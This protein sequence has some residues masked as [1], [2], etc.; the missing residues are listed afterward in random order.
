MQILE[1]GPD[2][3]MQISSL[4]QQERLVNHFLHQDVLE[5]PGRLRDHTHG[6]HQVLAHQDV[7]CIWHPRAC[8]YEPL[9][10]S[11]AEF[12]PDH[13]GEPQDFPRVGR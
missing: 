4:L 2:P 9:H 7:E 10:H 1:D 5:D 3:A 8:G 11:A 13:R 6:L 12:A